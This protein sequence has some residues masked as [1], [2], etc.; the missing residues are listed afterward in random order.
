ME[1]R[2]KLLIYGFGQ[3]VILLAAGVCYRLTPEKTSAGPSLGA[4]AIIAG[5]ERE[6]EGAATAADLAPL[7]VR[8]GDA[9]A[10]PQ[11]QALLERMTLQ[12]GNAADLLSLR[13]ILE[14]FGARDATS[15]IAKVTHVQASLE[16]IDEAVA[17][18]PERFAPHYNRLV[19]HAKLPSAFASP[20]AVAADVTYFL[21]AFNRQL[22]LIRADGRVGPVTV[23]E[24]VGVK[25]LASMVLDSA[26]EEMRALD[27]A[28]R[29]AD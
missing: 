19:V 8:L 11:A 15:T 24:L 4:Q 28:T 13:A 18:D 29:K 25:D 7:V 23:E 17:A 5:V 21:T 22:V 26:D 6:V 27:A 14:L 1:R 12:G 20:E 3:V 10:A 16:L 2:T 9:G